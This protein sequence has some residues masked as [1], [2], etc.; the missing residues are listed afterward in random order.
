MRSQTKQYSFRLDPIIMEKLSK[1]FKNRTEAANYAIKSYNYIRNAS[2]KEIKGRF[3]REELMG[4]INANKGKDLPS[5]FKANVNILIENLSYNNTPPLKIAWEYNFSFDF[6]VGKLKKLTSAQVYFIQE[7]IWR[8][9][10]YESRKVGAL[11]DFVD[12]LI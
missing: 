4:L 6:L 2:L 12:F 9:W 5:D 1:M 10:K 7:E 11:D 8:F 3:K